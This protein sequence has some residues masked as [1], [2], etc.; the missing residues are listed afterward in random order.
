MGQP[1]LFD[2]TFSGEHKM[3]VRHSESI[4][5]YTPQQDIPVNTQKKLPEIHH[6]HSKIRKSSNKSDKH[7][8][9]RNNNHSQCLPHIKE[10]KAHDKVRT[11]HNHW[12]NQMS[13]T[14]KMEETLFLPLISSSTGVFSATSPKRLPT[15][16]EIV[17]DATTKA[18][19][20]AVTLPPVFN[21]TS[22][23]KM[24]KKR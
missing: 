23:F 18:K 2:D 16:N 21:V 5:N 24:D 11:D 3:I 17:K 4:V 8:E 15:I 13:E 12:K 22:G 20:R 6:K 14:P 1:P 10:P 19:E 9:P 7:M